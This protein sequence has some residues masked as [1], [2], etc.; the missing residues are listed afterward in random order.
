MKKLTIDF[1][2]KGCDLVLNVYEKDKLDEAE[3][4]KIFENGGDY[5]NALGGI[6]QDM[7]RPPRFR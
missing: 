4:R 2:V 3:V 1:E 5:M 7:Q 6:A